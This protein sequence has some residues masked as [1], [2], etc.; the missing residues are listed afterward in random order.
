MLA[1]TGPA[2][3]PIAL[4]AILIAATPIGEC[5]AATCPGP[6]RSALARIIHEG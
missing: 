1:R 2:L 4:A 3:A 5:L 6:T